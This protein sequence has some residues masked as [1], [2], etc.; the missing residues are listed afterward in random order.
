MSYNKYYLFS[1]LHENCWYI[2]SSDN[3]RRR[4]RNHKSD[5][6]NGNRTCRLAAHGQDVLHLADPSLQF[7]TILPIDYTKKKTDLLRSEVWWQENVGIHK[8]GLNKRNDLAAVSRRRK[9]TA[10]TCL[11][12]V[13]QRFWSTKSEYVIYGQHI[14]MFIFTF[15]FRRRTII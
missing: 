13:G 7:L 2:G 14:W 5:W 8:F 9:K 6:K 10:M 15:R 11:Q 4:W 12:T 1:T 3:I